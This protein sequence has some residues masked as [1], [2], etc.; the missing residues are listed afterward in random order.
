MDDV[1]KIERMKEAILEGLQP[2]Y[3]RV[4]PPPPLAPPLRVPAPVN[5]MPAPLMP[6]FPPNGRGVAPRGR[7]MVAEGGRLRVAGIVVGQW[8]DNYGS[9]INGRSQPNRNLAYQQV[10]VDY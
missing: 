7:S 9:A 3:A 1:I 4:P 5:L 6:V 2:H 8:G 10:S